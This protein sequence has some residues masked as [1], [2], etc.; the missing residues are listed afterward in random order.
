MTN[1][2]RFIRFAQAVTDSMFFKRTDETDSDK[3][4]E[5][6]IPSDVTSST[7]DDDAETIDLEASGSETWSPVS[8]TEYNDPGTP[9]SFD[10]ADG[11]WPKGHQDIP[12]DM[13][14]SSV[15]EGD[16]ASSGVSSSVARPSLTR[17]I[18]KGHSIDVLAG[19]SLPTLEE[20]PSGEETLPPLKLAPSSKCT[21][22]V[23]FS[24][25]KS[26]AESVQS[27]EEEYVCAICLSDYGKCLRCTECQVP[28]AMA[29]TNDFQRRVTSLYHH[30]TALI[31]TTRIASLSGLRRATIALVV[32]LP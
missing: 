25:E 29:D 26:D 20:E 15:A 17:K 19:L 28:H 24:N 4:D 8:T 5:K 7:T 10:A 14:S 27:D 32:E 3:N 6:G 11:E 16:P 1:Q 9:N 21:Q 2:R 12:P 31:S 23:N 13:P 22:S 30:V 18:S